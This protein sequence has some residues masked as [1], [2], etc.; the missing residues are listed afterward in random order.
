MQSMVS[1]SFYF[2][3]GF[4]IGL[5]DVLRISFYINLSAF[6]GFF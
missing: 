1:D 2:F 6:F 3:K 4:K 5:S